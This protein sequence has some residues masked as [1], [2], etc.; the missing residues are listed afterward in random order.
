M[1]TDDPRQVP[2]RQA[3]R[4]LGKITKAARYQRRSTIITE[5]G[6][7]AA[8]VLPAPRTLSGQ[9]ALAEQAA[10]A[11][12]FETTEGPA[13]SQPPA[14]PLIRTLEGCSQ[15]EKTQVLRD[16]VGHRVTIEVGGA[17]HEGLLSE[18]EGVF[19]VEGEDGATALQPHDDIGVVTDHGPQ[20]D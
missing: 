1:S 20:A 17:E 8:M 5:H 3:Y 13:P 10:R 18:E 6:E 4:D 15:D 2:L 9:R 11:A 16:L 14:G 12:G 19:Y 7:P